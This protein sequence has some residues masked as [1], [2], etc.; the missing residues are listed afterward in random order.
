MSEFSVV[1]KSKKI[2][3]YAHIPLEVIQSRAVATLQGKAFLVLVRVA[4]NYRNDLNGMLTASAHDHKGIVSSRTLYQSAL[5]QLINRGLL[6]RTM[7]GKKNLPARY[8]LGWLPIGKTA[9]E[10]LN[11]RHIEAIVDT[12]R[13]RTWG[14]L[15][16]LTRAT[17]N[18][19]LLRGGQ[20][21]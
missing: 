6:V 12:D 17:P 20:S 7:Q 15:T 9:A 13:W 14:P 19:T 1:A 21:A 4:A 11:K 8:A 10:W 18:L 5:P 3:P 2:K 16:L